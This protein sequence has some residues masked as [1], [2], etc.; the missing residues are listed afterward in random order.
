M[1]KDQALHVW[2]TCILNT[3]CFQKKKIDK[4]YLKQYINNS[5][6]FLICLESQ[7]LPLLPHDGGKRG[8]KYVSSKVVV[9]CRVKSRGRSHSTPQNRD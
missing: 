2:L 6:D 5:T 9:D 4:Y 7:L 8:K 3:K 1:I